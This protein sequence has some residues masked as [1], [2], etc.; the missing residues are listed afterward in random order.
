M[1]DV[2]TEIA[3]VEKAIE[4]TTSEKLKRDYTKY[5]RKLYK[6]LERGD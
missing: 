1:I 4:K 5:L 3:R 6:K 2:K